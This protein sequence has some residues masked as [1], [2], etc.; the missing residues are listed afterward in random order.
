MYIIEF[1]D[2]SLSNSTCSMCYYFPFQN[3]VLVYSIS[4]KLKSMGPRPCNCSHIR[5]PH[6]IIYSVVYTQCTL[7]SVQFTLYSVQFRLN[8]QLYCTGVV[9]SSTPSQ[10]YHP[11]PPT[12]RQKPLHT[13][14]RCRTLSHTV[15]QCRTLSHTVTYM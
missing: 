12:R 9:I 11:R 6:K 5:T 1:Q 15:T 7:Y 14:T 10:T 2:N 13:V 4:E 8:I 3:N